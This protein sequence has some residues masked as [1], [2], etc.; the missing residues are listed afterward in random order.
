MLGRHL[1]ARTATPS[2]RGYTLVEALAAAVILGF[3]ATSI[4]WA[5]ASGF[6]LIQTTRENLRGSQVL[7]QKIESI[8][9]FTW[10]QINDT[11]NYLT[12]NFRADY[13][14]SGRTSP[15]GGT[16]YRRF[17]TASTRV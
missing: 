3:V 2:Q 14:P 1:S 5:L 15:T 16:K 7:L 6:T 17:V 9:L 4:Y 10:S 12:S 8:R 11:P 13:G